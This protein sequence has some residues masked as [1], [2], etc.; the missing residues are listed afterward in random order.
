MTLHM[1]LKQHGSLHNLSSNNLHLF[2]L[3]STICK[4][5]S[6]RKWSLYSQKEN[7]GGK[8]NAGTSLPAAVVIWGESPGK[9]FTGNLHLQLHVSQP[10]PPISALLTEYTI[11]SFLQEEQFC[12]VSFII[13]QFYCTVLKHLRTNLCLQQESQI[14]SCLTGTTSF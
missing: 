8:K 11:F 5:V 13:Q 3:Q 2:F 1:V 4:G 9:G 12:T 10:P 14:V 7:K 6:I